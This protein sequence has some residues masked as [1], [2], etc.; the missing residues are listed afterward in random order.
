MLSQWEPKGNNFLASFLLWL[1]GSVRAQISQIRPK[2]AILDSTRA[3]RG[4]SALGV[5]DSSSS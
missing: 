2:L 3:T 4:Q 1:I 5:R